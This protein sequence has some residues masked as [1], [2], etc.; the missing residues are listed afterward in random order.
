MSSERNKVPREGG[1]GGTMSHES[2]RKEALVKGV[3]YCC[4]TTMN[5]GKS[6]CLAIRRSLV[7]L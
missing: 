3:D 7:I 4:D 2:F 6:P 1:G 5:N